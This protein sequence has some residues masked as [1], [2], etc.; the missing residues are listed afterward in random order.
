MISPLHERARACSEGE[1]SLAHCKQAFLDLYFLRTYVAQCE[2]RVS[3]V[4]ICENS[5]VCTGI[6]LPLP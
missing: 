3:N 4:Y 5:A 2:G 6:C 1:F